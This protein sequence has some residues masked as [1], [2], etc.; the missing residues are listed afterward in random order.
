MAEHRLFDPATVPD[1]ATPAWYQD[2]DRAPHWEQEGHRERL[3][4]ALDMVADCQRRG[5]QS[6]IDVGAGDGG[7]LA[8]LPD[9]MFGVGCDL[10]PSN[11]DGAAER[12]V[13][14][15]LAD[16]VQH[17]ELLGGADIIVACELLEHL[18]SPHRTIADIWHSDAQWF[19]AS[20]PYTETPGCHYEHHL[21]C[22]DLAGYRQMIEEPGW[23]VLRHETAWISQVVLAGRP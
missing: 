13:N 10:Q 2:R 11:V 4:L 12:G 19:I 21:W 7:L 20:S 6:V 18:V 5:A 1:C 16:V 8:Q 23:R 9:G 17:P 22:W 14:I 3:R 15:V